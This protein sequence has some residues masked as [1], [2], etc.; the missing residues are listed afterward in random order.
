MNKEFFDAL[1][2]L[3]NENNIPLDALVEKIEQGI[4]KAVRKEYPDCDDFLVDI[5]P[6]ENK[7]DVC[8]M[9]NVVDDEPIDLNEINIEEARTIVPTCSCGDAVPY[10][11]DTAKFG[12]VAA[13]YAK[14]S[15]R[16][17]VKEFEKE[18]L[19]AQYPV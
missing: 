8:V 11:L 7:F 3:A 14:Q 1:E 4:L 10:K 15:I 2:C 6:A 9:R 5:D 18:K 19:I 16:H 13:Q 17:D 12:R